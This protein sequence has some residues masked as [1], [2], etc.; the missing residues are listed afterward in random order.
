MNKGDALNRGVIEGFFGK[1]WPHQKRL[2]MLDFIASISLDSYIYAPKS[3]RKLRTLWQEPWSKQEMSQLQEL[4]SYCRHLGLDFGVGLSPI[5]LYQDLS[6]TQMSQLRD[7]V[8]AILSLEPQILC[9]CFDDMKADVPGLA[10]L[11]V[12]LTHQIQAWCP[13]V[14]IVL[15]P[16]YYTTAPILEEVF[17]QRPDNYWLDLKQGL[18]PEIGIF[19]TGEEVCS[20]SYSPEHLSEVQKLLGD[21]IWIWDNYPVN[22]GRKL[23]DFLHL[24]APPSRV[25]LTDYCQG[26]LMNPM[27]QAFLSQFALD[28]MAYHCTT[29][30]SIKRVLQSE[31]PY[32]SQWLLDRI[33][34][35]QVGGL[36]ELEP[37]L[38][39]KYLSELE[40]WDSEFSAEIRGWLQGHFAFD[41]A[42]LT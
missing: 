21:R 26:H 3:D 10:Q 8:E 31:D 6:V 37:Q 33:E 17:G 29:E 39:Q 40:G 20:L 12:E 2:Q 1:E 4:S 28:S 38:I 24:Q 14:R 35:F 34:E 30:E 22:D 25:H 41:P 36:Q 19:W 32:W 5:N 18:N 42:C 9:V 23:V 16:S 7:K 11:Q 15:C 13:Q 27:N